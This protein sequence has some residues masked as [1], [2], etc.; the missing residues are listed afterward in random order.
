MAWSP[1]MRCALGPATIP[2]C[3][4]ASLRAPRTPHAPATLLLASRTSM[5]NYVPLIKPTRLPSC[6]RPACIRSYATWYDASSR[7][8]AV[9]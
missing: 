2:A 4:A 6:C 8:A 5:L 3:D 1:S 9:L 7:Y